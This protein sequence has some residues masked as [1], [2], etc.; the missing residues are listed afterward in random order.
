MKKSLKGALLSGLVFP[1]VGQL[2][3]KHYLRGT[4]LILAVSACLA[5]VVLKAAQQA[6]AILER[7]ETEGGA[8]DMVA[9]INSASH[10]SGDP[11]IESASILMVL[12]WIIG[13]VDAY[14]VGKKADLAE[15][16]KDRGRKG[17]VVSSFRTGKED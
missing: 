7:I 10:A 12:C 3:L 4:V 1:G 16:S 13:I 11:I 9:I 6:L 17:A 2:W 14:M 15:R 8:V 5:V